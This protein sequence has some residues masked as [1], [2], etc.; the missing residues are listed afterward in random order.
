MNAADK[1]DAARIDLAL[2]AL[3][4]PGIR[5]IWTA[6]AATADFLVTGNLSDY[7]HDKLRGCV[8][9]SPAEFVKHWQQLLRKE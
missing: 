5:L 2:S 7:P 4:L 9:V 3:R 1:I 6:L 8:V